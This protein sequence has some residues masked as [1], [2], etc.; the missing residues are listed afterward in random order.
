MA[1]YHNIKWTRWLLGPPNKLYRP[2]EDCTATLTTFWKVNVKLLCPKHL[3]KKSLLVERYWEKPSALNW[4]LQW[5]G[6]RKKV[7][8]VKWWSCMHACYLWLSGTYTSPVTGP[9]LF[10]LKTTAKLPWVPYQTLRIQSKDLVIRG[11]CTLDW[12]PNEFWNIWIQSVSGWWNKAQIL[13]QTTLGIW[14]KLTQIPAQSHRYVLQ[15][16][17][18]QEGK[19][20]RRWWDG[21]F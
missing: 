10:P 21:Y 3:I 18:L 9:V 15:Y 20:S 11:G 1:M 5:Q 12:K 16:S 2:S 14:S 13:D 6:I 19:G 7:K 17:S 4:S 8:Y